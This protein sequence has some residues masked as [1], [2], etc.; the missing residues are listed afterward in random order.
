MTQ[1]SKNVLTQFLDAVKESQEIWALQEKDGEDW[2]VLD[3]I[4]FENAEAM[5]LWSSSD[6]AMVHCV[7]EWADYVPNKISLSDW[8]EFWVEDLNEDDIIIGVNWAGDET[9]LEV[10]LA[11]FTQALAEIESFK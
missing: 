3:S 8:F 6:L 5:P 4:N 11:D 1:E 10:E 2:V 9:C 7:E